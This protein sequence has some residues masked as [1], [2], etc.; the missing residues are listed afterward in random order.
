MVVAL[1]K[2]GLSVKD[3][4]AVS[5]PGGNL[6]QL[7]DSGFVDAATLNL[8]TTFFAQRRGFVRLLDI[9][10]MAEMASGGLTAMNRTIK[11]RPDEVK[12]IIRALQLGKRAML[13]SRKGLSI[14]SPEC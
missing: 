11:T 6:V 1:E 7:L 13:K 12:R 4:V 3:Y 10:W 14:S 8:P 5:V 2:S 9:G